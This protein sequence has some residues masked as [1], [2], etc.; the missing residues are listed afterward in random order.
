MDQSSAYIR[1]CYD[2]V[3]REYAD[4]FADELAH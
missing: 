2:M 1:S 4:R 3:A